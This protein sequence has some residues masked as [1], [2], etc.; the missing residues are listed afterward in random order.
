MILRDEG[1]VLE[2]LEW[3]RRACEEFEN[4][5][6]PNF[7]NMI[8]DLEHLAAALTL[9]NRKEEAR[10]AEER[11]KDIRKTAAEVPSISHDGEAPVKLTEGALLIE[12]D[13][14]LRSGSSVSD[15][16]ELGICLSEV[17]K[18]QNLGQ[19]QGLIRIP[20]C[21]T[22]LYYGSNAEQ[23]F[24]AIESTLRSDSR[25]DGAVITIRQL[26]QQ[27]EVILPRRRVN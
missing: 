9:L 17:L 19:W 16:A 20:E 26:T 11:I 23:M 18:E 3:F 2:S 7:E 6:S 15:I 14:G 13:G 5:P 21:S 25:F 4:Q 27:R 8:E 22:L 24:G 10:I 12:L 1:R